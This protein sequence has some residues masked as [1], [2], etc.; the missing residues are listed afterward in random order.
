M[1]RKGKIFANPF[2]YAFLKYDAKK[3]VGIQKSSLLK[4]KKSWIVKNITLNLSK[5][6]ARTMSNPILIAV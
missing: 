3:T 1:H 6:A 4:T 2:K 5:E